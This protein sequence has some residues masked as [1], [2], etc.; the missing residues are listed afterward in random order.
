MRD[1]QTFSSLKKEQKAAVGLLS[2]GTF[3]E[4]FDLMLYV[5][6]AVVLNELFFPKTDPH[7]ASIITAM[8]F[9]ATFIFRPFGALIIGYIGDTIGRK[10]L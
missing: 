9:C 3:L 4:Y 5:H 2:I 6:M 1:V 8:S 7:T 10:T